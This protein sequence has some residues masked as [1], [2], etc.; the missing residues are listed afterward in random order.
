MILGIVGKA[1]SGKSYV[2]NLLE[3]NFK[4]SIIIDVD[5]VGHYVLTLFHVKEK[6]KN[7]FGKIVF[8]E[9]NE[10]DRKELGKIVF[11]DNK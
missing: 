11:N 5:R 2:S 6:I 10:I 8:D 7:T 4:N 1:G 9:N 3:K